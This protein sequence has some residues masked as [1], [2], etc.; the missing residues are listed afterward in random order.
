MGAKKLLSGHPQDAVARIAWAGGSRG[1]PKPEGPRPLVG[2]RPTLPC[3]R[4]MPRI[5]A[6]TSTR[7]VRGVGRPPRPAGATGQVM[8]SKSCSNGA[9]MNRVREA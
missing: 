1:Q 7:T 9:G 4:H 8:H 2:T 3:Y 5:R 6:P